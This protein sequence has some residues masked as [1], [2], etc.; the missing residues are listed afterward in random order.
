[1]NVL[2][3][4]ELHTLK[5]L[6]GV[7]VVALSRLRAQHSVHE[8]VCSIPGF[9]QWVEDPALLQ[10]EAWVVDATRIQRCCGCGIG[11]QLQL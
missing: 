10:A 9:D 1:M 6:R 3:A 5:W 11:L 4:N 2:N 7:P 8:D